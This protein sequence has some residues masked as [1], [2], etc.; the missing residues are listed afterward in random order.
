MMAYFPNSSAGA[1][2][3][4]QCIN[5]P[6]PNDAPCPILLT[7]LLYNYDQIDIPKLRDAM[8]GLVNEEGNCQM[9]P[10]LDALNLEGE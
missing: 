1:Y 6:I 5:C 2:L 8:N 3:D 7:Q 9:K 4:E 10:L